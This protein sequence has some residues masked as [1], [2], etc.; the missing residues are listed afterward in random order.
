M[1][2][3]TYGIVKSTFTAHCSSLNTDHPMHKAVYIE[4]DEEVT[5]VIDRLHALE[6]KRIALVVPAGAVLLASNVNIRLLKEES[7]DLDKDIAIVTTDPAGRTVASQVGFT[8]YETLGAARDHEERDDEKD[9]EPSKKH[10]AHD[11]EKDADI[12][13]NDE[14]DAD[15][16]KKSLFTT[17]RV[18]EK[19]SLPP[20]ITLDEHAVRLHRPWWLWGIGAFVV[21][22]IIIA[23]LFPHGTVELTVYA[24]ET[25]IDI[26]FTVATGAKKVQQNKAI[27]LPGTWDYRDET[28]T[29]E[30][31]AT[32]EKNV[33]EKAKGTI[34][35][36]N[37][38]GR[39]YNLAQGSSFS[40]SGGMLFTTT[41]ALTI[42]GAIVSEFGELIP[43]KVSVSVEAKENGSDFNIQPT[44][45]T[46]DALDD[47]SGLLYGMSE[48]TFIEGTDRTATVVSKEDIEQGKKKA[49]EQL[50]EKL[51]E[52]FGLK[53]EQVFVDGLSTE[54]ITKEETDA[55]EG[56]ERDTFKVSVTARVSFLTFDQGDFDTIFKDIAAEHVEDN[57][58]MIGDGYRTVT[59]EVDTFD[60][61]KQEATLT[62]TAT[63]LIAPALDEEKLREEVMGLSIQELRKVISSYKNVDLSRV[64]LFPPIFMRSL[65]NKGSNIT[66]RIEYVE[67]RI[68]FKRSPITDVV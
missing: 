64:R 10:H 12:I 32:G 40:S 30:V 27:L 3:C 53:G 29:A 42:P 28:E 35:I 24:Q 47:I 63:V 60:A 37:R 67:E 23:L 18:S 62:G 38:S 61:K 25:D 65:P 58:R 55:K 45:F 46:I 17:Q 49:T 34:V 57:E 31:S 56:E 52:E 7:E 8:V 20:D 2:F 21:V 66:I 22:F 41:G 11:D 16:E 14:E 1:I 4:S 43:G 59:W 9:K 44:R 13:I 36:Y 50:K 5:S 51:K 39:L 15:K 54:E 68:S 26:D 19:R 6:E 33:G 48:E